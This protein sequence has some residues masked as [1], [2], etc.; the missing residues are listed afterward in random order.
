MFPTIRDV[1][2]FRFLTEMAAKNE[3]LD[4]CDIRSNPML[5]RARAL[6]PRTWRFL[7]LV[8]PQVTCVVLEEHQI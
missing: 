7:P 2:S 3:N 6:N 5:G 4:L 8:D 1:L